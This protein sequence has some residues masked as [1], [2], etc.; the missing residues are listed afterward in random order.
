ME[1]KICHIEHAEDAI[2]FWLGAKICYG[3]WS[4]KL[5]KIDDKDGA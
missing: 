5:R 2:N 3:C 1:C 4:E